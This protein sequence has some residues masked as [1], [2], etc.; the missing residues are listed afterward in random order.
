MVVRFN[1]A[2]E[3]MLGLHD[4]LG[5]GHDCQITNNGALCVSET[6]EVCGDLRLGPSSGNTQNNLEDC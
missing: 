1:P 3:S 4:L 5:I 6:Y 2:L